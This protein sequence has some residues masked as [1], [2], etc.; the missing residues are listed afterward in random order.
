MSLNA[1]L[2]KENVPPAAVTQK[3]PK[4]AKRLTP[5]QR[6]S[7]SVGDKI[8]NPDP[9]QKRKRRQRLYGNVIEECGSKKYRV[10][11]DDGVVRE[12]AANILRLESRSA[13]LPPDERPPAASAPADEQDH[14]Q[15]PDDVMEEDERGDPL[16]EHEEEEGDARC[17]GRGARGLS[18]RRHW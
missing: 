16:Q 6:V 4:E 12:C 2:L 11:F 18:R 10:H 14:E 5:G 9:N 1:V 3:P 15:D 7:G 17:G 13:F 8:P